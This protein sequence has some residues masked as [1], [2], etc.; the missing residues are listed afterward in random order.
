MFNNNRQSI[1]IAGIFP[2]M[3]SFVALPTKSKSVADYIVI[4]SRPFQE[5]HLLFIRLVLLWLLTTHYRKSCT[6]NSQWLGRQLSG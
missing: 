4:R 6:K 2:K 3:I 1:L 5:D